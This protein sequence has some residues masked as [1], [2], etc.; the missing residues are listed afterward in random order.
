ME[1]STRRTVTD[2]QIEALLSEQHAG[3]LMMIAVCL[4]ALNK[5]SATA[6]TRE[7][8][9][10]LRIKDAAIVRLVMLLTVEEARAACARVIAGR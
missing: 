5:L 10:A 9:R 6:S 8:P 1:R 2:H 3:D 7:V 4:R